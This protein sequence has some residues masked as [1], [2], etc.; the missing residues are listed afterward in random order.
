MSSIYIISDHGKLTGEN[1][2]LKMYQEDGTVR[3]IFPHNTDFLLISGNVSITGRAM[4][5]LMQHG[6]NTVFINGKNGKFNGK[7]E[8]TANK[9]IFLRK[10]QYKL[11]DSEE[12]ALPIA[13]SIVIAKIKNQLTFAQR[14]KRKSDLNENEFLANINFIKGVLKECENA[15]NINELRGYEGMCAKEYFA[16]MRHNILPDW[17]EFPSRSMN[18]PKTNVNAVLSFI[19]TL[20]MYRVES[21]I[22][23]VSLDA[24]AG[25]LHSHEY[26]KNSLVFD[27]MEEFRTPIADTLACSL[28]NLNMLNEDD[29]RIV[30]PGSE[31]GNYDETAV[32]LTKEGLKKVISEFEN[33]IRTLVLY[34][35]K[36][37]RLSFN[38]IIF[39]QAMQFRRVIDGTETEYKGF[40]FK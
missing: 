2:T 1:G 6:I 31:D 18:P 3:T 27:L 16:V 21:A 4:D 24:M 10:K 15:A 25:F 19:Y 26:G 32:L 30:E 9:N 5:V 20:L 40:I 12:F 35:P 22:E 11:A 38:K 28:F 36:G 37:E 13:K 39:E 29:F 23:A 34:V 33:K 7:L 8:F 14:I 17:A